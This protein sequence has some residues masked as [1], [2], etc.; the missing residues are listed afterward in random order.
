MICNICSLVNSI[1]DKFCKQCIAPLNIKNFSEFSTND[2]IYTVSALLDSVGNLIDNVEANNKTHLLKV[3]LNSF[4]LRPE[5]ALYCATEAG[6]IQKILSNIDNDCFL[7]LGCGNGVHTSIINGWEFNKEFDVFDDLVVNNDDIY[8][9][10]LTKNK[11]VMYEVKGTKISFGID[12]KKNMIERANSLKT[13]DKLICNKAETVPL[14]DNT[15]DVVYSNVLRDF[16]DGLLQNTLKELKRIIKKNGYLI[17]TTPTNEYKDHLYYYPRAINF[18]N[19][20]QKSLAE[21]YLD[22]DRG[23]SIFCTQQIEMSQWIDHLKVHNF[24]VVNTFPFAGRKLMEFW[25]TGLRPYTSLILKN[26]NNISNED[27]GLLK[28]KMVDFFYKLLSKTVC[29]DESNSKFAFRVILAKK[30]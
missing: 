20:N 5:T 4:W 15:V 12:I 17:F 9:S 16:E 21:N 1:N 10:P 26:L 30:K 13:F 24:E 23:R 14:D 8:N 22:L 29:N 3:Y 18:K 28:T 25:D 11:Q 2:F 27:K 19:N 6:I 7:D